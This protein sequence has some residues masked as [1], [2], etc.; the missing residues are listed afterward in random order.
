MSIPIGVALAGVLELIAGIKKAIDANRPDVSDE[1]VDVAV[2]TLEASDRA[3]TDAII[4][5]RAK[6]NG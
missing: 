4:R 3:L 2:S 1:D 5:A 6:E